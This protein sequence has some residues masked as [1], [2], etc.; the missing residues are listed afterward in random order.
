MRKL[1]LYIS[2]EYFDELENVATP[3]DNYNYETPD[4]ELVN[5]VKNNLDFIENEE[6]ELKA[7]I[8]SEP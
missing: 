3:G 8:S 2:P 4:D 6:A 1:N 5:H 7:I